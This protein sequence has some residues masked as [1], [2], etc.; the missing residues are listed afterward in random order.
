MESFCFSSPQVRAGVNGCESWIDKLS[1]DYIRESFTMSEEI[2]ELVVGLP[3]VLGDDFE[4][5]TRILDMM[6]QQREFPFIDGQC[7]RRP[8]DL[9]ESCN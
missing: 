5:H 1:S 4:R 9:E 8:C 6:T 3:I 7:E 2:F